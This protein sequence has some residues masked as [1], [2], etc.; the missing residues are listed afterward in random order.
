MD[1]WKNTAILLNL[2]VISMAWFATGMM[3]F[4]LSIYMPEFDGNIHLLFFLQGKK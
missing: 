2:A 3:F 1:I 4:G